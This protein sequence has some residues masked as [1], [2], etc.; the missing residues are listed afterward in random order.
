MKEDTKEVER[1]RRETLEKQDRELK[2]I[3]REKLERKGYDYKILLRQKNK[4]FYIATA[5]LLVIE[6]AI[7]ILFIFSPELEDFSL[8]AEIAIP[9]LWVFEF[10]GMQLYTYP[11]KKVI[12]MSDYEA[13]K[14][15]Q[16]LEKEEEENRKRRNE[17]RYKN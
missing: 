8:Y 9:I 2:K 12:R 4:V 16:R 14:E 15:K 10:I 17:N 6:I 5:V 13:G 7:F 3:E 11:N 1:L